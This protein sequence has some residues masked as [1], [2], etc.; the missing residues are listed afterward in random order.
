MT[1][2]GKIEMAKIQVGGAGGAHANNFIRCL[3]ESGR[4]DYLIGTSCD[5]ADLFLANVDEE[6]SRGFE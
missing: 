4:G 5:V 6:R 1:S 2:D 3:N